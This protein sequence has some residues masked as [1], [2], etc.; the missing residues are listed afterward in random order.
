MKKNESDPSGQSTASSRDASGLDDVFRDVLPILFHK[1]KN[2]LTPI[3]GY[4]QILKS[5]AADGFFLE[6]LAKIESNAAELADCLNVM[7]EYF[8]APAPALRPAS[9]NRIV[10]NWKTGWQR[11]ADENQ[12][13]LRSDLASELPDLQL[14]AGQITLLLQNLAANSRSA[15][16]LKTSPGRELL[17]TTRRMAGCVQLV[18]RDNGIGIDPEKLDAIWVP[19]YTTFAGGAGLGLVVCEKIIATH[20][21]RCQVRS[22]PGEFSEFE[23]SFPVPTRS[24]RQKGDT[25]KKGSSESL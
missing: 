2:K 9:L 16:A 3:V 17:L 22:R 5:R 10:E 19:F 15:L 25:V 6:R 21:G 13:T 18:V 14:H 24:A 4:A 12:I 1:L 23:I 7:K 20:G 11:Q 8:R